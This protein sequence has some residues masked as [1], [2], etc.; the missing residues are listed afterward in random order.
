MDLETLPERSNCA[1]L[2]GKIAVFR[3]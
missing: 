1:R 3:G 2:I